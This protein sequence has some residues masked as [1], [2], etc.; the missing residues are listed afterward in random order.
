MGHCISQ[1]TAEGGTGFLNMLVSVS[2]PL[3]ALSVSLPA[4]SLPQVHGQETW[5]Q[6]LATDVSGQ[7]IPVYWMEGGSASGTASGAAK[8]AAK[9][10]A[11]AAATLFNA[12]Q[13]SARAKDNA[14][15]YE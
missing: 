6:A 9:A 7:Q 2:L 3:P 5:Q 8:G 1:W 13:A 4:L 14:N 12:I 11:R 15:A 10:T